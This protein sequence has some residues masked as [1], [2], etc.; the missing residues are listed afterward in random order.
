MIELMCLA[1][2]DDDETNAIKMPLHRPDASEWPEH[3]VELERERL[4]EGI[5]ALIEMKVSEQFRAPGK[6]TV[7]CSPIEL[8]FICVLCSSIGLVS[9]GD[10]LSYRSGHYSRT[11]RQWILPSIECSEMG[12][13]KNGRKRKEFQ[14][15]GQPNHRTSENRHQSATQIHRVM[16]VRVSSIS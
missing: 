16:I 9:C 4:L 6:R 13:E 8:I 7:S 10:C 15:K 2:T 14:R 11:Y 12:C 5:D 1:A 3:G